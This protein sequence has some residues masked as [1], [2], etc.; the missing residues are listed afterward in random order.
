MCILTSQI[1]IDRYGKDTGRMIGNA[2]KIVGCTSCGIQKLSHEYR[3][4]QKEKVWNQ[5]HDIYGYTSDEFGE[6]FYD[7]FTQ[8]PMI[9]ETFRQTPNMAMQRSRFVH[10]LNAT[11]IRITGGNDVEIRRMLL[12]LG[13]L[14]R[15]AFNVGLREMLSFIDPFK[16]TLKEMLGKTLW[17]S[18]TADS[19]AYVSSVIVNYMLVGWTLGI[20]VL[21]NR[22]QDQQMPIDGV[23]DPNVLRELRA[24]SRN[25]YNKFFQLFAKEASPGE[26]S[27][28]ASA[29]YLDTVNRILDEPDATLIRDQIHALGRRHSKYHGV[30]IEVIASSAKSW[31][32]LAKQAF[33]SRF[34]D[35]IALNWARLWELIATGMSAEYMG[36]KLTPSLQEMIAPYR[37]ESQPTNML[38]QPTKTKIVLT[39]TE[40]TVHPQDVCLIRFQ[41][42]EPVKIKAGN[43][44]K[45]RFHL[46]NGKTLSRYYSAASIPCPLKGTSEEFEY[47]VKEVKSGKVSPFLVRDLAVEDTCEFLTVGGSFVLPQPAD[48]TNR[49]MISAGVGIVAF[50][51]AIRYVVK[52][53]EHGLVKQK[54]TLALIHS[55]RY[56]TY[57]FL[58]ELLDI[59]RRFSNHELF[60]FDLTLCFTGRKANNE[61]LAM[62]GNGVR[63]GRVDRGLLED[64]RQKF[65]DPSELPVYACGPRG[66]QKIVRE[67]LLKELGHK[68]SKVHLEFF[69]L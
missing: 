5:W 29:R 66:F 26:G 18:D 28:K 25:E 21:D 48:G 13:A 43:F 38:K 60:S 67:T 20:T 51:S 68:R 44:T 30:T 7:K 69:D 40:K 55:E 39:V 8:D 11:L 15:I 52:L 47:L 33:G 34:S 46:P 57:P 23:F 58:D 56:A 54:I 4:I 14:H 53:V 50:M 31:M 59:W 37:S 12:E 41:S 2:L 16:E 9:K 45:L 62:L 35:V 36:S 6:I 3:E 10:Q 1:V 42:S 49:L 17:R 22:P 32:A 19:W 24:D 64:V 61:A 65:P 27:G 63:M